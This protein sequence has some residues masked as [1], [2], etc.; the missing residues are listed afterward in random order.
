VELNKN[1]MKLDITINSVTFQEINHEYFIVFGAKDM[2]PFLHSYFHNVDPL[3]P[4]TKVGEFPY[5]KYKSVI[6]SGKFYAPVI[7]TQ[8]NNNEI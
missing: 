8:E 1:N 2:F 6:I 3:N 7:Q 4:L 5:R